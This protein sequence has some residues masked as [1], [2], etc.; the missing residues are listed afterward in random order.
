MD[1]SYDAVVPQTVLVRSD[2]GEGELRAEV[3]ASVSWKVKVK[4]DG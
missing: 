4:S 1:Y 3:S 2:S